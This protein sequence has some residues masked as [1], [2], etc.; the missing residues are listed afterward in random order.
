MAR[1]IC[2]CASL[3]DFVLHL[4]N[5][6]NKFQCH[7]YEVKKVLTLSE[8]DSLFQSIGNYLQASHENRRKYALNVSCGMNK[9]TDTILF[10]GEKINWP[11]E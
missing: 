9:Y 4:N 3:Q 1:K 6:K 8:V 2:C 10:E 7:K 11:E 5:D